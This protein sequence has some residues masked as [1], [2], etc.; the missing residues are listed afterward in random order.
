[1]G[2]SKQCTGGHS[3]QGSHPQELAFERHRRPK[4]RHEPSPR[5][6]RLREQPC[7]HWLPLLLWKLEGWVGRHLAGHGVAGCSRLGHPLL[8]PPVRACLHRDE[9]VHLLCRRSSWSSAYCGARKD[10]R[11]ASRS[12]PLALA[13]K[14]ANPSIQ[15]GHWVKVGALP[16]SCC[17]GSR[18]FPF[19]RRVRAHGLLLSSAGVELG[20]GDSLRLPLL[21]SHGSQI[22]QPVGKH[23]Q[24]HLPQSQ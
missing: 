7:G 10:S 12:E 13:S 5:Q 24:A 16:P 3:C 18:R 19:K 6:I 20:T 11:A 14:E 21:L 15:G 22:G 4:E 2:G 9:K 23:R 1:M 17:L 8:C